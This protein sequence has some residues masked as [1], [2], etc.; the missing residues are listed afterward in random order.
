[1]PVR[2]S[3]APAHG[4]PF[5]APHLPSVPQM[6]ARH[7]SA[8]VHA[9]PLGPRG[10]QTFELLQNSPF[11][12]SAELKQLEPQT[13]FEQPPI[14]HWAAAVQASPGS[15]P[16]L[17]SAAHTP[18]AHSDALAQLPPLPCFGTQ[19]PALQYVPDAQSAVLAQTMPH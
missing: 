16:H 2:Q 17:P 4:K 1:M 5:G 3:D 7:W 18:E 12:H 14:R 8:A 15:P 9:P 10:T 19:A 13:R 6:F 11:P